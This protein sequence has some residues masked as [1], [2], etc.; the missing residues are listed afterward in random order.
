VRA[1][2]CV[3]LGQ[4]LPT[5]TRCRVGL[6]R[7]IEGSSPLYKTRTPMGVKRRRI[8]CMVSETD[9]YYFESSSVSSKKAPALRLKLSVGRRQKRGHPC[10]SFGI[11][12]E[13]LLSFGSH[14]NYPRTTSTASSGP[15]NWSSEGGGGAAR[16]LEAR[17]NAVSSASL[18]Q[19]KSAGTAGAQAQPGPT[20]GSSMPLVVKAMVGL[21]RGGLWTKWPRVRRR[22]IWP[23]GRPALSARPSYRKKRQNPP[24]GRKS[25]PFTVH[26]STE[27]FIVCVCH[28]FS[29]SGTWNAISQRTD[30]LWW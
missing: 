28:A 18:G 24:S 11:I 1:Y 21:G 25:K 19:I 26:W 6:L 9:S 16:P 20:L 4:N 13:F 29:W 22:R 14:H 23:Q 10:A 8:C 30:R 15:P 7:R 27:A 17:P 3:R 12:P 5:T 2:S